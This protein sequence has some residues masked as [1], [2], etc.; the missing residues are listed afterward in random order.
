VV[1]LKLIVNIYHHLMYES[2]VKKE[3]LF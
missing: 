3:P 2:D 1:V